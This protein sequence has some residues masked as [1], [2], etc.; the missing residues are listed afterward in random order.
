MFRR[1]SVDF[2]LFSILMDA[3][4][5]DFSLAFCTSI[6]PVFS[7]TPF[8]KYIPPGYTI[9]WPL[10][11]IF[12]VV[13]IFIFFTFSIYDSRKRLSPLDEFTNLTA[14]SA[15]TSIFLAGILYLSYREVSRL[16]F[17]TFALTAYLGMWA[18][19]WFARSLYRKLHLTTIPPR[20]VLL[21]G[22]DVSTTDIAS[23]LSK[24][25]TD[26]ICLCGTL[27]TSSVTPSYGDKLIEDIHRQVRLEKI[28]DIILTP[29]SVQ[30]SMDELAGKLLR[31]PVRLWIIPSTFQLSVRKSNIEE[32]A[33]FPMLDLRAPALSDSQRVVKRGM[34]L[35]LS[36]CSLPFFLP[37]GLV[38]GL[39]LRLES[40][41]PVIFSHQRVGE[42]G[43]LFDFYKFRTMVAG[44]DSQ[45][46]FTHKVDEQGNFLHKTQNDPRV[47]RLGRFLRRFSLDE[48]PQLLNVIK[49]DMSL[50]GPRPEMPYLVE[51]Y[52]DWQRLRFTIPQGMTGWWQINGRSLKPMHLNTQD[53]L[54]YI[55]NYSIWLDVQILL[56]TIWIVIKGDGAF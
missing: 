14:S 38:V 51:K 48:I 24:L 34:D 55:Q 53:D 6:R 56:R 46:E 8:A 3:V 39:L 1:F 2:T 36:I 17:V 13:W 9:P 15:L 16:L 7:L 20:R 29:S 31:L 33:G 5:V 44:A 35:F 11:L 12:P 42:N 50:V 18:W 40:N 26:G 23:A 41:R 30:I 19:R 22:A 4:W 54:Y 47:T 37:L 10:F 21:V 45:V 52:A 27:S 28:S 43:R 32:I 49:G 25:G